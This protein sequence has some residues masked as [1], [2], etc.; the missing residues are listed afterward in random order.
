MLL[1]LFFVFLWVF[2]L[3]E[4]L[5]GKGATTGGRYRGKVNKMAQRAKAEKL[6]REHVVSFQA[7]SGDSQAES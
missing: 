6:L 4:I 1:F 7:A 3:A 5:D 2:R